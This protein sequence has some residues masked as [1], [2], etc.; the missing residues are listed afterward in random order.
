MEPVHVEKYRN[1]VIKIYRDDNVESPNIWDDEHLFL[2]SH[3]VG[4]FPFIVRRDGF[5]FTDKI[6]HAVKK[7]YHI[8]PLYAHTHGGVVLSLSNTGYP[9]NDPCVKQVGYVFAKKSEFRGQ[10][11]KTAAARLVKNWNDYLTLTV[12][13]FEIENKEGEFVDS[14]WG[15]YGN[16]NEEGGALCEAQGIVRRWSGL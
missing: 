11:G 13:G 14:C 3:A 8:F 2:I 6:P 10:K 12:Y 5:M 15:F 16:Y 4:Y 9:L 7:A 1:Y